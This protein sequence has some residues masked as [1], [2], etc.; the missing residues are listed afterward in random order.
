MSNRDTIFDKPHYNPLNSARD[1]VLRALLKSV[2]REIQLK[3]A[4][5]VGCGVGHFS[6]LLQGLG[7]NVLALDGRAD[8]VEEA[9]SRVRGV[10]FR[11]ADAE[12]SGIRALGKFDLMLCFGLWYHLENPFVAVRNL[13]ALTGKIAVMEGVCLPGR[14]AILEVRDEGPTEDQGLRHVALYPTENGMVKL[15]YRSGFPFVYRF[16]TPP[17]HVDYGPSRYRLQYRTML[18]ASNV[19]VSTDMLVLAVEPATDP[20]TW[21]IKTTVIRR[22]LSRAKRFLIQRGRVAT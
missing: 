20:E 11:V 18:A 16:R 22:S 21:Q 3:T 14:E 2:G 7:L 19:P 4:V 17:R 5:D 1:D 13:F 15:L 10:D 9:R 6:A 8:N 12:D